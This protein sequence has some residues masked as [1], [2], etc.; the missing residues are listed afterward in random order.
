[1]IGFQK[2]KANDWLESDKERMYRDRT[3]LSVKNKFKN[4]VSGAIQGYSRSSQ[5]TFIEPIE[6]IEINND[7]QSAKQK[8]YK[9]HIKILTELTDFYQGFTKEI[10]FLV[11]VFPLIP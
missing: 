2:F 4:K 1:M 11:K 7:I 3:V 9:E 5:T 8:I 6:I 10:I